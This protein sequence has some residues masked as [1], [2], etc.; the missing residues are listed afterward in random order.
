[1]AGNAAR[2]LQELIDS[3]P[4]IVDYLFAN[5][6]SAITPYVTLLQPAPHVLPEFTNWRDEQRS[7]WESVG[8]SDQTF[9]MVN[10]WVRGRD[11][12]RLLEYLGVNSFKN[13]GPGKAKQFVACAPSG[14]I[15]GDAIL[16]CIE[17]ETMVLVG[18]DMTMNW[19]KY[20]AETGGFDVRIEEDPLFALN[21]AGRRTLYRFEIEGPN[22]TPLLE[23]LIGGPVPDIKFFNFVELRIAG[24][25]VWVM[26]HSM[27]GSP[28]FELS[29]PWEDREAVLGAL[30]DAGQRFGLRRLGPL[31]YFT[32][33]LES[34]WFAAPLPAIYTGEELRPYREWL[35]VTSAEA[36]RAIGGSFYSP[37]IAD[38][39]VTPYEL[40]YERIIKFDHEFIGRAA[41][42]RLR[43]Q[44]HRKKVTLVW[45]VDDVLALMRAALF[46]EGTP[47]KYLDL[48]VA[49]YA[50]WKYD[51]VQNQQ[52]ELIGISQWTGYLATERKV[53]SLGLVDEAY[54]TPGTEVV[55]VWGEL[56]GGERSQP[57][58]ERHRP[59]EVRATV[60]PVPLSKVAQEYWAQV[61]AHR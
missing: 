39:Y 14:H 37:N 44:P 41:L 57:W 24:R 46:E 50:V 47:A 45:N 55:V 26:R 42:E 19:I 13:F 2:T 21:P 4:S 3:V 7:W 1:M 27:T 60:A 35:P 40:G 31:A 5:Q 11:A 43:E 23:T 38:Y 9:H 48:P 32:N 8:L 61:K 34:G 58:I 28:G 16:Y 15:V 6:K 30:L 59:F 18:A 36:T 25:P 12:V 20:H 56:D 53:V 29:G 17:P 22:A 51:R 33:A 10:L 49:Q 54:A 52:G